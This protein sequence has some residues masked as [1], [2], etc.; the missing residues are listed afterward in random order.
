MAKTKVKTEKLNSF[1][2]ITFGLWQGKKM[3]QFHRT[4]KNEDQFP[5]QFGVTKA[6]TLLAA[7]EANGTERVIEQLRVIADSGTNG[8][9]E[10]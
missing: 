2:H 6:R 10:E 3:I 9:G 7:M 1:P 4:T 8:N 5:F